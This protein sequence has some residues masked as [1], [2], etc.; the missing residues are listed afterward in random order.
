MRG[1]SNIFFTLGISFT[2]SSNDMSIENESG[3]ED[4]STIKD[5]LKPCYPAPENDKCQ[6]KQ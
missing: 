4:W 2:F 6:V 5:K 1:I 3:G